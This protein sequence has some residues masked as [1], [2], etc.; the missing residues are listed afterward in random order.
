MQS[1]RYARRRPVTPRVMYY[2]SVVFFFFS[3]FSAY[4]INVFSRHEKIKPEHLV[5]GPGCFRVL[6]I[7]TYIPVITLFATGKKKKKLHGA[8]DLSLR[9]LF[10]T[11][12]VDSDTDADADGTKFHEK[13]NIFLFFYFLQKKMYIRT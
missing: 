11:G 4:S 3:S 13:K 6:K 7:R 8:P 10:C 5:S 9:I 1:G 2:C 12:S